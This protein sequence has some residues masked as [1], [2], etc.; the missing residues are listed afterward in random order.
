LKISLSVSD[1]D[2][3]IVGLAVLAIIIHIFESAI[4]SPLPGIKPGLANVITLAVFFLFGLRFAVWVT[5][6][7]VLVGSIVA[8]TFLSPT[9]L[10]SAS[11]AFFSILV[12]YLV[13]QGRGLGLSCV[14]VA[15]LAS[16]AH[17]S[18]QFLVAYLV[19]IQHEAIFYL[20]PVLLTVALFFGL[21]T[22]LIAKQLVMRAEKEIE[23]SARP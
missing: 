23:S 17:I 16:M 8:G 7:R 1:E 10:L 13:Y 12:L 3:R 6:L 22:G 5:V 15:V 19:F 11:G 18:G 21:A 4:P 2:Y 14:G 9:F 20:L